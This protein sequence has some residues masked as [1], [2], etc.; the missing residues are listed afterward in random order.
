MRSSARLGRVQVICFCAVC[1]LEVLRTPPESAFMK[2]IGV[3]TG[4]SYVSGIDYYKGINE[5]IAKLLPDGA[6]M[7]HNSEMVMVSVDCDVYVRYLKDNDTSGVQEYLAQAAHK[8][9]LVGVDFIVIASN[10]AHICYSYLRERFPKRPILHIVDCVAKVLPKGKVGL[11]GTE[12][13]MREGSWIRELLWFISERLALHGFE[14]VVPA[15]E[16]DR[17]RCYDIICRELSFEIF[18]DASRNFFAEMAVE[19]Y[20]CGADAGVIL[21][22]TEIELLLRQSDVPDVPLHRSAEL[23]IEAAARIQAGADQLEDYDPQVIEAKT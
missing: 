22:C 20:Q 10:T 1:V 4:I 9:D 16:E 21:G 13:T 8:L 6:V 5:R 2:T 11:L 3:I 14:V 7:P 18:S 12:P 17:Q 19:L 15:K 23:H